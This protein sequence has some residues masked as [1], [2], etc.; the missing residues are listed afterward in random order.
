MA[1][2]AFDLDN[3][4]GFFEHIGP[5]AEFFS[6]DTLENQFNSDINPNFKLSENIRRRLRLAERRFV[7]KLLR[8]S[9]LLSTILRP[10]LDA[11]ILPLIKGKYNGTVRAVC[12]YSNTWNTF[13][14]HI[15]KQ[16]IEIIYRAPGF[17]DAVVDASH[18]IREPDWQG[19]KQGEQIKTF[20][21]LKQIFR[22]MCGVRKAIE[23]S[24]ILFIDDRRQKHIIQ[25]DE[26]A[27]LTYF[28]PTEFF[29]RITDNIRE[30]AFRVGV[31][32]LREEGLLESKEYLDSDVFHCLK[33][34]NSFN[35]FV[36]VTRPDDL[37]RL[38]QENIRG[39]GRHWLTFKD[40]TLDIRKCINDVLMPYVTASRRF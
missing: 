12:I 27:G 37:F 21:V 29:P 39:A 28:K 34:G 30:Q 16:I 35:N 8:N 4:L 23:P 31:E 32:T 14:V 15:A 17:F 6:V 19:R 9:Q 3:T 7:Y 26:K 5:W 40:D 25:E 38:V 36:P 1:L 24:D 20:N 18:P 2:V 33:Y 11:M 22:V 10:N 13:S